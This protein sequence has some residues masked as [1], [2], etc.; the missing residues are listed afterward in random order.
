MTEGFCRHKISFDFNDIFNEFILHIILKKNRYTYPHCLSLSNG[1]GGLPI[2]AYL[3]IFTHKKLNF[4]RI[5]EDIS[6]VL[7]IYWLLKIVYD[8]FLIYPHLFCPSHC[9][10][11][12]KKLWPTLIKEKKNEK[13]HELSA[14]KNQW[15][16]MLSLYLKLSVISYM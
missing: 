12:K 4:D 14:K 8:Y 10:N 2:F 15:Y 5:L 7:Y 16:G 9:W 13:F 6:Y 11:W 1:F 3:P